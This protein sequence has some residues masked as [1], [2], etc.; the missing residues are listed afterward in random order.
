[1][2]PG[3]V[4]VFLVCLLLLLTST[5]ALRED[6][7][8]VVY[9][10]NA[11]GVMAAYQA[12]RFGS[13]VILVEPSRWLG[14]MTGGGIDTLDWGEDDIVGGHT[15]LI[16][17][18]R[19]SNLEYRKAFDHLME[20]TEN[21]TILYEHRVNGV[22]MYNGGIHKIVLDLAPFDKMGCPPADAKVVGNHIL[23]GKVF[24]DASYDGELM[25]QTKSGKAVLLH[26]FIHNNIDNSF[27]CKYSQVYIWKRITVTV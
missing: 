11:A 9:T 23:T 13:R 27:L 26:S 7:D 21:V 19:Y 2:M 22:Y 16:L 20:N 5:N 12:A 17:M 3:F 24:I 25:A 8:V 4:N 14:G 1:M 10:G 18:N 6:Y 15:R